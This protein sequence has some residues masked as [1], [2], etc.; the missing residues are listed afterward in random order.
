MRLKFR[1]AF[2]SIVLV[3]LFAVPPLASAAWTAVPPAYTGNESAALFYNDQGTLTEFDM[4]AGLPGNVWHARSRPAG[5]VFGADFE[6][7][8]LLPLSATR[9]D[10]TEVLVGMDSA[11]DIQTALRPDAAASFAVTDEHSTGATYP[12]AGVAAS[13]SGAGLAEWVDSDGHVQV[14]ELSSVGSA[15]GPPAAAL[16][17][18]PAQQ[19]TFLSVVHPVLDPS[20]AAALT[21]TTASESGGS[22]YY[23]LEQST[24]ASGSGSFGAATAVGPDIKVEPQLVSNRSGVAA[25]IWWDP[26]AGHVEASLRQPG[27]SFGSATA[28]GTPTGT[29]DEGS[30]QAGVMGDGTVVVLWRDYVV[31]PSGT[32]SDGGLETTL[33]VE[34][35]QPGGSWQMVTTGS[36]EYGLP[37]GYQTPALAVSQST[38]A[39]ATVLAEGQGTEACGSGVKRVY[40]W[41]GAPGTFDGNAWTLLPDQ[42]TS[43]DSVGAAIGADEQGD[44][45]V[46][47]RAGADR[48]EATTGAVG[49][50]GGSGGGGSGGDESPQQ[51]GPSPAPTPSPPSATEAADDAVAVSKVTVVAF[52]VGLGRPETIEIPIACTLNATCNVM[53]EAAIRLY[54]GSLR[55]WSY[56]ARPG[57]KA[58]TKTVVLPL[59]RVRIQLAAHAKGKLEIK[60][61][62]ATMKR[63]E[64]LLRTKG[65]KATLTAKLKVNG[66][67]QRHTVASTLR[68]RKVKPTR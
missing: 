66:V 38:F 9:P 64:A 39:V 63:L 25:A 22:T 20:G 47:W 24:R 7:P 13:S 34:T 44:V 52:N 5:G 1:A 40:A 14:A 3:A 46:T 2:A 17:G 58:R 56:A 45:T 48:H 32:C 26:V 50:G 33:H 68:I 4:D 11:H 43:S 21:W 23:Q 28:I 55:P 35:L 15:F 67:P 51:F 27:G 29:F 18:N 53:A 10:G 54:W 41:Q 42:A 19:V 36:T 62:K 16:P 65:A 12:P 49:G 57:G 8:F 31:G 59:P 61:P 6:L 30:L 37:I 60:V